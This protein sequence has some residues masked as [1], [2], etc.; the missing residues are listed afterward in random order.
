MQ[1]VPESSL[2]KLYFDAVSYAIV[3]IDTQSVVQF[4][5]KSAREFLKIHGRNFDS[6][7]GGPVSDIL[8]LAA[9]LARKAMAGDAFARGEGRVVDKGR[10]LF[11][12]ITPL[13]RDA[14][15]IGAVISLQRPE[16]FEE[17]AVRMEGY[18]TLFM[19]LQA[20]FDSS[21]DGIWVTD[22]EGF[23]TN[24]NKASIKLNGMK[25]VPL[26]GRNIEE[27][28]ALGGVDQ[29]VTLV[30]M[31]HR[32]QVSLIQHI[33]STGRQILATGTP[34]FDEAGKLALVVVNERDLTELNNLRRDLAIAKQS[35]ESASNELKSFLVL[36]RD[37]G[38]VVAESKAM[39]RILAMALKLA[40]LNVS[41]I[42]LTGESGVGKGMLA[43]F[44]HNNSRRKEKPFLSINCAALPESLFESE[45][46]GYEGG[47]F[48]G[49]KETGRHGLMS[50]AADGTLFLDEV[51]E[52]PLALQAK[53]LTCLDQNEFIPIGGNKPVKVRCSLVFA[54]NKNLE[55]LVR[56]KRF[57][58]DF[59]YRLSAFTLDIPP[60]RERRDDIF[61]L[62]RRFLESSNE[63]F[64]TE[65]FLSQT[66]LDLLHSHAFNGNVRELRSLI[67]KA[68]VMSEENDLVSYLALCLRRTDTAVPKE[69]NG[70]TPVHSLPVA[71]AALER[72]LL[73]RARTSCAN[74]REMAVFL[75]VNQSTVVRKLAKY[76][77][78]HKT[79]VSDA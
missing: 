69:S 39:R 22:G 3:V 31:K 9:P 4:V 58:E 61:E 51:G 64:K 2:L 37:S 26:I 46:F 57:R 5:N 21:S 19:Q 27:I 6:C 8:P 1:H 63:E 23:I 65:K 72:E 34:V 35:Q 66:A 17:M 43:K 68:V 70:S 54:T 47:A 45:L 25:G 30:V 24:V 41:N 75:G 7:I 79:G 32:R 42:L 38:G 76:G 10:Q 29:A 50:L 78:A 56:Q 44:L 18:Q 13:M 12:E 15:L 11:F 77:L 55:E 67:R 33:K 20:V 16:R 28:V 48:T 49:A 71:V 53:L 52:M 62:S 60:L 59:F 73:Q 40:Q 74:T 36:E 14:E